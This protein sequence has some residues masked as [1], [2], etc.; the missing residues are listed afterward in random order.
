MRRRFN[1]RFAALLIV[2]LFIGAGAVHGVHLWQLSRFTDFYLA[3]ARAAKDSDP[4]KALDYYNRRVRLFPKKLD[5]EDKQILHEFALYLGDLTLATRDGGLYTRAT[6]NLERAIREIR[7]ENSLK[8]ELAGARRKLVDVYMAFGRWSDARD[9]IDTAIEEAQ[10]SEKQEQIGDLKRLEGLC[11]YSERNFQKANESLTQAIIKPDNRPNPVTKE[12]LQAYFLL[13]VIDRTNLKP[14]QDPW[15]EE[16]WEKG[17]YGQLVNDY[18]DRYQSFVYRAEW[19]MQLLREEDFEALS[20]EE[21]KDRSDKI[22]KD[23]KEAITLL[24]E[25]E[26]AKTG[27]EADDHVELLSV[28]ISA[29]VIA[30]NVARSADAP[31]QQGS[32]ET[33][34]EQAQELATH[35]LELYPNNPKMHLASARLHSAIAAREAAA[36]NSSV[37]SEETIAAFQELRKSLKPIPAENPQIAEVTSRQAV[38]S[39]IAQ[40]HVSLDSERLEELK[41]LDESVRTPSPSEG[42]PTLDIYDFESVLSELKATAEKY[43]QDAG[44]QELRNAYLRG[45]KY[46]REQNW[47]KARNEFE[48]VR[49]GAGEGVETIPLVRVNQFLAG[50][51]QRLGDSA[52][53]LD[54]ARRAANA[55][56]GSIDL[57]LAYAQALLQSNALDEARR[58]CLQI[59][60]QSESSTGSLLR[61]NEELRLA[62]QRFR[63]ATTLF[64][65]L[66]V[67]EDRL[68]VR[69]FDQLIMKLYEQLEDDS[70]AVSAETRVQTVLFWAE[71]TLRNNGAEAADAILVDACAAHRDHPRLYTARLLLAAQENSPEAWER[72]DAVLAEYEQHLGQ[73]VDFQLA[74]MQY[75]RQRDEAE[76]QKTIDA[77]VQTPVP[78]SWTVEDRARFHLQI[79]NT[80]L[81]QSTRTNDQA[82]A[83]E[84]VNA[85][86][87]Q[88]TLTSGPAVEVLRK[89]AQGT[90]TRTVS[91]LEQALAGQALL[92]ELNLAAMDNDL[93][94]MKRATD[95]LKIVDGSDGPLTHYAT[96]LLRRDEAVQVASSAEA[97]GV[98]VDSE[99]VNKKLEA[100]EAA[101]NSARAKRPGWSRIA[102]LQAEIDDSQGETGQAIENYRRAIAQGDQRP[103]VRSRLAT[104]LLSQGRNSE[105]DSVLQEI[106]ELSSTELKTLAAEISLRM[107]DSDRALQYAEDLASQGEETFESHMLQGRLYRAGKKFEEAEKEF[108]AAIQLEPTNSVGLL[109]LIALYREHDKPELAETL[110]EDVKQT[111]EANEL[112]L[113]LARASSLLE[114]RDEAKDR[115]LAA[116]EDQA[117]DGQVV[118]EAANFL[119][120]NAFAAEAEPLLRAALTKRL[121]VEQESWFRRQLAKLIGARSQQDF[122]EAM[123]LLQEIKAPSEDDLVVKATLLAARGQRTQRIQAIDALKT[124]LAKREATTNTEVQQTAIMNLRFLLARLEAQEAN[125]RSVRDQMLQILGSPSGSENVEYVTWYIRLL[126]SQKTTSDAEF[127]LSKLKKLDVDP[128]VLAELE[129]Q[130]LAIRRQYEAARDVIANYVQTSPEPDAGPDA[131]LQRLIWGAS[132][133]EIMAATLKQEPEDERPDAAIEMYLGESEKLLQDLAEQRPDTSPVLA[134]FY[135]RHGDFDRALDMLE[136]DGSNATDAQ[137]AGVSGAILFGFTQDRRS[138]RRLI[139]RLRKLL[140]REIERTDSILLR[141]SLGDILSWDLKLDAAEKVYREILEREPTNAIALNNLAMVLAMNGGDPDQALK[142]IQRAISQIGAS[143]ALLDTLGVVYLAANRPDFALQSFEKSRLESDN[144]TVH[145]HRAEA[146]LALGRTEESQRAYAEA[147]KN[148]LSPDD[149]HPMD[150]DRFK[151]VQDAMKQL[152]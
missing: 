137:I 96:A 66:N 64:G 78:E 58:E 121:T 29:A 86:R 14:E 19:G 90:E 147:T 129:S 65:T 152:K 52:G 95:D 123:E 113:F 134:A 139:P 77:T 133:F 143:G 99:T 102:L 15:G 55:N 25:P 146:L 128:Q 17:W 48:T 120:R 103:E 44:G 20:K 148:G 30:D 23:V 87:A 111:F 119:I 4:G 98:E 63:L 34:V 59:Y 138:A 6:F 97:E 82:V 10:D 11:Y 118:Q 16:V 79:G 109:S 40:I 27:A 8:E 22:W 50:C 101:L 112:N 72:G 114:Q 3:E 24:P 47:E 45:Q 107:D 38:L 57:R 122:E 43:T 41:A 28:A 81:M 32:P 94:A 100:A 68:A 71:V 75:L 74:K 36:G 151:K 132:R 144:P 150:K 105:A 53:A 33:H 67:N 108:Q 76:T 5:Q 149:L 116:A 21:R 131:G 69:T 61:R 127:W 51:H 80:Y 39:E 70:V 104:L 46:Y 125:W 54:A 140:E 126:L 73:T 115:Y 124:V 110:I 142:F 117:D 56:P 91:V 130:V 35:G 7:G 9:H 26:V 18:P 49:I 12:F 13:A 92:S 42:G 141:I 60:N 93:V 106:G 2:L 83:Q 89:K 136:Q 135:G 1:V 145:L 31:E 85:A 62:N 88:F 37:A 84:L